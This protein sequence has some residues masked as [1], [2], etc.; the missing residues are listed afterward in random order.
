M[1]SFML[2]LVGLFFISKTYAQCDT[3]NSHVGLIRPYIETGVTFF[4]NDYLKNTFKTNSLYNLGFGL[5][6]GNPNKDNV[7]PFIQYSRSNFKTQQLDI[8]NKLMDTTINIKEF[9]FGLNIAVKKIN[10][11]SFRLKLGYIAA[12]INHDIPYKSL[13][14]TGLYLGFGYEAKVFKNS[15]VFVG[16]SFDFMKKSSSLFRDYDVQKITFG[17]N[18]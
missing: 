1:K 3:A 16:Y 2:I 4:N 6:F 13:D 12:L 5:R 17:F 14:A 10:S 9:I 15:R 7:L 8:N 11:N 18:L